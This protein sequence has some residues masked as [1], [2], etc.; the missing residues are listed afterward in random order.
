MFFFARKLFLFFFLF[1]AGKHFLTRKDFFRVPQ[2]SP[3][4][5]TLRRHPQTSPPV[6]PRAPPVRVDE[7]IATPTVR[8]GEPKH[9]GGRSGSVTRDATRSGRIH[10]IHLTWQDTS[11]LL[12]APSR[13]YYFNFLI[14]NIDLEL[15][16]R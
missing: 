3:S 15:V 7:L 16:V 5:V 14:R 10:R 11:H 2:T 1:V 8:P 9:R 4:D 13:I 6:A 12:K